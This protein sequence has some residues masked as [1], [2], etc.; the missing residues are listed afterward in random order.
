MVRR[1]RLLGLLCAAAALAPLAARA[2]EP[3]NA[4]EPRIMM[5]SG[6]V[7]NVPDAFDDGDI[8]DAHVSLGFQFAAKSA[9][10]LRET[11]IAE[12]GLTT[13]GFTS[14]L[15][16]VA[17]YSS[18]IA[19]LTPRVDIGIYHDLAI[20]ARLPIILAYSQKLD[21]VSGSENQQSVVA[22]GAPGEQLFRLPFKSPDRSGVEYLALGID[23]DIFNQARDRSK[24][25]WLLGAEV[26]LAIGDPMQAC[27]PDTSRL[28][29][30]PAGY[31]SG[32][33]VACA[34]PSDVNR[35]G[36]RD[37]DFEGTD[38]SAR[39][40]GVTRGTIGLEA[41]TI[42]SKRV[43]YVEPYGG[44][45]ALAEFYNSKDFTLTNLEGSLVN[46]PPIRGKMILGTMIIPW[47]NRE[48]F[49]RFTLDFR[50]T[51]EYVSEGRDYSELFDAL[52]SSDAPS[53]RHPQWASFERSAPWTAPPQPDG[54]PATPAQQAA[55]D[56]DLQEQC[57][58]GT[59]SPCPVKSVVA[60]SQKTYN[61]GLTDVYAYGTYRISAS[62]TWQASEYVKFSIG[63]GFQFDQGHVI[64]GDQPCNPSFK[65]DADAVFKAGP[66]HSGDDATQNLTA[67]GIPNPNYRPVVNVVGR[68]FYVD[69]AQTWDIAISGTVMF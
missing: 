35:D 59:V 43:K 37:N 57:D 45:S 1:G 27:N 54:S 16:N 69:A 12:P 29:A 58:N 13:G 63:G 48:K 8:F 22:A 34:D 41:H 44:F 33:P 67:T 40:A 62:A 9:R 10:I 24:P 61:T 19:R 64:T 17:Q 42:L 6:E 15:M 51:G 50:F 31:G 4:G 7:T 28:N 52:G 36:L 66:C 3:K 14:R 18:Q 21:G 53:M 38:L 46:H 20:Y 5:E 56:K 65:N 39:Q 2:D 68:R 30:V 60:G 26:R 32:T 55:F 25:T 23:L 47:E 49:G 11:T